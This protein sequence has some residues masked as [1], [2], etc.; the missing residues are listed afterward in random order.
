MNLPKLVEDTI[1]Y[2]IK[3][4]RK[5]EKWKRKI[6]SIK[7]AELMK[8]WECVDQ[9]EKLSIRRKQGLLFAMSFTKYNEL[10]IRFN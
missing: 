2:Y 4:L 6:K 5:K 1:K 9:Y 8:Y 7:Y 10:D 3:D